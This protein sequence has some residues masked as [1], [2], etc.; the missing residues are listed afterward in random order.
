MKKPTS[1]RCDW[2]CRPHSFDTAK[3]IEP[4]GRSTELVATS[5]ATSAWLHGTLALSIETESDKGSDNGDGG[6]TSHLSMGK[7]DLEFHQ[8]TLNQTVHHGWSI[9]R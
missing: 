6:T 4:R 3:F 5:T 1:T 8:H 7:I 2:P 9:S